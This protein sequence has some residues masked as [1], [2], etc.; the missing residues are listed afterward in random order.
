MFATPLLWRYRGDFK[1]IT[2]SGNN[3]KLLLDV[4]A[5]VLSAHPHLTVGSGFDVGLVWNSSE[6]G[7]SSDFKPSLPKKHSPKCAVSVKTAALWPKQQIFF[8]CFLRRLRLCK[9]ASQEHR[10][11]NWSN[12]YLLSRLTR[13]RCSR[14]ET[15]A[16]SGQTV[17]VKEG[18]K[19]K[20]RRIMPLI[21]SPKKSP[22]RNR[23]SLCSRGC[24]P[25][26]PHPRSL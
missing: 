2:F 5:D 6:G 10:L 15:V 16:H 1:L 13:S 11:L 8:D 22:R 19:K 3:T 9:T 21:P 12:G 25:G 4:I 7:Q 17:G 14:S 20:K 24:I 18:R 23:P 26:T